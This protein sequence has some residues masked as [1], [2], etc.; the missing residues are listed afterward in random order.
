MIWNEILIFQKYFLVVCSFVRKKVWENIITFKL[1]Q[2]FKYNLPFSIWYDKQSNYS[3]K[4]S[5][6]GAREE[7][8]NALNVA[9]VIM[10]CIFGAPW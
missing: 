6:H 8:V 7:A 4:Y 3:D 10:F 9:V 5:N 2:Q 1:N